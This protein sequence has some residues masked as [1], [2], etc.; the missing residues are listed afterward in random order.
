M[1]AIHHASQPHPHHIVRHG[2]F[3]HGAP[4]LY[5]TSQD[6]LG[7][8][9]GKSESPQQLLIGALRPITYRLNLLPLTMEGDMK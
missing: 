4:P 8:G 5:L 9:N 2:A 3:N 7:L 1:G 6:D